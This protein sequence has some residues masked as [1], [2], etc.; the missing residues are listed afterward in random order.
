M[1]EA[2]QLAVLARIHELLD[3]QGIDYWLFGGWAVDF[4]AGSVTRAHDHLDIAV[5]LNGHARVA[6]VLEENG[7]SH[8]PKEHEDSYTRY[9]RGS[10]RLELAF[11]DRSEDGRVYTPTR[12]GHAAWPDRTFEDDVV[13]LL[14]VRASMVTLGALKTD[15]AETRDDPIVAAKDR[16]DLASLYPFHVVGTSTGS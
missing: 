13:E 4:H 16:A 9:E 12:D 1:G 2:E 14:G 3:G 5:W 11:L 15:K 7:W 6:A 10:V 8:T